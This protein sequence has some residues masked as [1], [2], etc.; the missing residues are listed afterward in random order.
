MNA[1]QVWAMGYTGQGMVIAN[2]DTG[3]R[4]SHNRPQTQVRG[5]G[6]RHSRPQL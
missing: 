3:M 5:L 1:P 4:W 2:Q 6:R